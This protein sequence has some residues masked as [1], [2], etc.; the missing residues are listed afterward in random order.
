MM[1]T[2]KGVFLMIKQSEAVI[3]CVF[4]SGDA[5]RIDSLEIV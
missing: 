2:T 3:A 4:E 5:N 1:F